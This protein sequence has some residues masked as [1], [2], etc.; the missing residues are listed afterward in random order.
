MGRG[1]VEDSSSDTAKAECYP[2]LDLRREGMSFEEALAAGVILGLIITIPC[3]FI[4][5]EKNN[6]EYRM[7]KLEMHC[8]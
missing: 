8:E 5:S 2:R 4:V 6:H 1:R 3:C 7:K